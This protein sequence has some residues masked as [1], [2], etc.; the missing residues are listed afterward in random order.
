MSNKNEYGGFDSFVDGL[1]LKGKAAESGEQTPDNRM[2]GTVEGI[3]YR[4]D[5]NG[6]MVATVITDNDDLV[7]I[8]GILPGVDE[9]DTITFSGRS[10]PAA[11]VTVAA[12]MEMPVKMILTSLP[13]CEIMCWIQL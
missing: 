10:S 12:P 5:D 2:K 11:I 6:Y 1:S 3:L 13:K 9:G 7:N 4:N 8:V